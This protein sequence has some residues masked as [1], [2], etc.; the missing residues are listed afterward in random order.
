MTL[1][2]ITV[3]M[4]I[5]PSHYDPVEE[6]EAERWDGIMRRWRVGET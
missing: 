3:P 4:M 2:K 1:P 6:A 5:T